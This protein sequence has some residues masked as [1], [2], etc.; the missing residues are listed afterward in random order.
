MIIKNETILR[1]P[2]KKVTSE[3]EAFNLIRK[4]EKELKRCE[5]RGRPGIGLAAPQI[6]EKKK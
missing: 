1:E 5:R 2:C 6:G 3:E 4:L